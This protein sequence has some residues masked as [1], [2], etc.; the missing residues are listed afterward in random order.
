MVILDVSEVVEVQGEVAANEMLKE[1]W[2]LIAIVPSESSRPWY[3]LGRPRSNEH[4]SHQ[5]V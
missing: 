5:P 1:G 4:P 2:K 3:I